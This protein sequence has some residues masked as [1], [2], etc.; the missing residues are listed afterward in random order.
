[1]RPADLTRA[2]GVSEGRISAWRN[3]GTEPTI[4][5]A[6]ALAEALDAPLVCVLVEAGMFTEQEARHAL[7]SYSVR[8]LHAE[9]ESRFEQ[10]I[11][12]V[13]VEAVRHHTLEQASPQ[14]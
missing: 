9:I 6:R 8:E 7:S 2:S 12:K 11:E 14:T 4:A 5:N 13:P 1:V 3:R 10:L